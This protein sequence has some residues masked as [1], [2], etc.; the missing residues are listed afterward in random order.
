LALLVGSR[1]QVH[2][3]KPVFLDKEE[4]VVRA[5]TIK[6]TVGEEDAEAAEA[7]EQRRASAEEL[8]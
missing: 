5:E 7:T 4:V 8:Q 1:K 3:A 2:E 6:D